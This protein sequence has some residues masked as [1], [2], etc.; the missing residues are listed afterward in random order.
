MGHSSARGRQVDLG[1][2][3]AAG[4]STPSEGTVEGATAAEASTVARIVPV[5]S[6]IGHPVLARPYGPRR[7][8]S[9]S[10]ISVPTT[11][12]KPRRRK[13]DLNAIAGRSQEDDGHVQGRPAPAPIPIG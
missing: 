13:C 4:A 7:S 8:S 10:A 1:A 5:N 12:A 9:Q 11:S 3:G 6:G 2:A